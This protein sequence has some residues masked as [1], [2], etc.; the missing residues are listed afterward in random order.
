MQY[1]TDSC[2][3]YRAAPNVLQGEFE[4][5]DFDK[6]TELMDDETNNPDRDRVWAL[7][8]LRSEREAES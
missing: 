5:L 8:Q 1:D 6:L 4:T 2:I 3:L 7:R